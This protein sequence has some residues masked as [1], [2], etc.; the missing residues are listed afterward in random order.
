MIR[1]WLTRQ[2]DG[3][4]MVT[5]YRPVITRVRGTVHDDAYM[6]AGEPI[7][8]RHLCADGVA[9]HFGQQAE[10]LAPCE[11]VRYEIPPPVLY[12]VDGKP[13]FLYGSPQAVQP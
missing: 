1:L 7:G 2:R 5:L 4:Y 10:A 9:A 8:I 13:Q 3:N 6:Q 12:L 11:S